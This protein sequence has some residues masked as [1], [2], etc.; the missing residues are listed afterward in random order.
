MEE[1][2]NA[3]CQPLPPTMSVLQELF[4]SYTLS[5]DGKDSRLGLVSG[6]FYSLYGDVMA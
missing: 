2:V 4:Q 3:A 6:L 1:W 5:L